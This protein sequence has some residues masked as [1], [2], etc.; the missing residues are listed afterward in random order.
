MLQKKN[1][2][3]EYRN[4]KEKKHKYKGFHDYYCHLND[5]RAGTGV[6]KCLTF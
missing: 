1:I 4:E 6:V 2:K 3:Y 5:L